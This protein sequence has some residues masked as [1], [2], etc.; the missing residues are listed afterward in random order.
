[1]VVIVSAVDTSRKSNGSGSIR[2]RLTSVTG[3][4]MLWKR[5]PPEVALSNV[6]APMLFPGQLRA[7][8]CCPRDK[9]YSLLCGSQ[10][11]CSE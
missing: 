9:L 10:L 5:Q 3:L 8:S 1:M 11:R 7:V 4:M 6:H 2:A